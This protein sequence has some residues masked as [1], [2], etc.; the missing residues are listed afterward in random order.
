[1]LA[2]AL[3]NSGCLVTF[4]RG[5]SQLIPERAPKTCVVTLRF[6]PQ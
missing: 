6:D 3:S 2:L 5:I 4:D 1:M